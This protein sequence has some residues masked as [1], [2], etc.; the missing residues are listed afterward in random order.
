MC[1]Q[2]C[3]S[4]FGINEILCFSSTISPSVSRCFRPSAYVTLIVSAPCAKYLLF[5]STFYRQDLVPRLLFV[6][7]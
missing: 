1:T 7:V 4:P 2:L 3:L 5:P 6:S